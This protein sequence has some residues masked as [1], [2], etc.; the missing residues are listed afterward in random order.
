MKRDFISCYL[1]LHP[2]LRNV[3]CEKNK[4]RPNNGIIVQ[5]SKRK[6]KSSLVAAAL[7]FYS[8]SLF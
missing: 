7:S 6:Y 4:L 3:S 5:L 1:L 2:T 8:I